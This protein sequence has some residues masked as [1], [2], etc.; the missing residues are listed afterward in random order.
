MVDRFNVRTNVDVKIN[1]FINAYINA[2]AT[3]YNSKTAKGDYWNV[4]T[5]ARPN[6]PQNAA[7][8]IPLDMIDPNASAAW[9]LLSTSGNIIDGKY[10]LGGSQA[11]C[12]CSWK[13]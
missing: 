1:D 4:A 7:P 6:F 10:F 13:Q 11:N 3:F 9:E 12:L 2:N 5:T 8:L